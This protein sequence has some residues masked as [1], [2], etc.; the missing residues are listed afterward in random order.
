MPTSI[1]EAFVDLE[2]KNCNWDAVMEFIRLY[3]EAVRATHP[4]NGMTALHYAIDNEMQHVAK[5]L[6]QLMT[7][8]DLAIQD[9]DGDTALHG[10]ALAENASDQMTETSKC[11]VEKNK[12]L[13]T[14]L[15]SSDETALL[16]A[17]TVGNYKLAEYL[18]SVTPFE[19]IRDKDAAQIIYEGL[20]DKK[21]GTY[22]RDSTI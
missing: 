21:L 10:A 6:V 8:D 3:P 13:L 15:N 1:Y 5:E 4:S 17:F 11:M 18:Y 19:S 16:A 14:I 2:D 7:E 9:E 20:R 22:V 12:K